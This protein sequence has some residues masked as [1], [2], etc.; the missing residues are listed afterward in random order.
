MNEKNMTL[1]VKY[2]IL[3]VT[4]VIK[5]A[6]EKTTRIPYRGTVHCPIVEYKI[7]CMYLI[8][9]LYSFIYLCIAAMMDYGVVYCL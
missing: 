5:I 1:A 8:S 4:Y 9:Y 3:F 6:N 7:I 2:V